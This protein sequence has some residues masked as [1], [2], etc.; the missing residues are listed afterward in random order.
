MRRTGGS[1]IKAEETTSVA[2]DVFDFGEKEPF[3][4]ARL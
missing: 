2:R 1:Y 4:S 3:P